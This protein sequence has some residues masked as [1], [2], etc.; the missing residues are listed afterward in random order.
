MTW[1]SI[2]VVL[3]GGQGEVLSYLMPAPAN[4]TTGICA[5]SD[6]LWNSMSENQQNVLMNAVVEACQVY[7]DQLSTQSSAEEEQKLADSGIERV[8]MVESEYVEMCRLVSEAILEHLSGTCDAD[9]LEAARA[10]VID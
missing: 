1:G 9:I 7:G 10:V 2:S 5:I 6:E 4:F 3:N 8:E